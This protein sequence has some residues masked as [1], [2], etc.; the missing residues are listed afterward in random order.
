M[1]SKSQNNA[2]LIVAERIAL[3][4][5]WSDYG[6]YCLLREKGLRKQLFVKLEEFINSFKSFS[7]E[8]KKEF[9]EFI[10]ELAENVEDA[11]YGPLPYQMSIELKK[12][13]LTWI[14]KDSND[15]RPF[16]WMARFFHKYDF[17]DK[18]LEI[19]PQDEKAR[20]LLISIYISHIWNSTH[21]LPDFYIGEPEEDLKEAIIIKQ[22]INQLVD[23][24]EKNYWSQE[25][26]TELELVKSFSEWKESNSSLN[27]QSW[28]KQNQ[29]KFDSGIVAYYYEK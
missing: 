9:T 21:H 18:A 1:I 8:Q 12:V 7:F 29:R 25:L 23:G 24:K 15:S 14:K 22:H 26:E 6:E 10:F 27:F 4:P 13:L 19:N 5:L 28:A 17:I 3:D 2:L 11:D 20:I 16:R